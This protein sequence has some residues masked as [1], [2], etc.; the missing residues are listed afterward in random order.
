MMRISNVKK[1]VAEKEK[2][3]QYDR[4]LSTRTVSH[5]KK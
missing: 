1:I 4:N 3:S 5:L 2:D